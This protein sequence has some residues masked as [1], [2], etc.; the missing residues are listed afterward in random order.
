MKLNR[1]FISPSHIVK[2]STKNTRVY[3][4]FFFCF[5]YSSQLHKSTTECD[6]DKMWN[7]ENSN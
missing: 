1:H 5:S 2:E 6:V 7:K 3:C 4:N